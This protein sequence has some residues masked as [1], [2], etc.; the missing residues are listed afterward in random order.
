MRYGRCSVVKENTLK[1]I[2]QYLGNFRD[3]TR[4]KQQLAAELTN[5]SL[6]NSSSRISEK[7]FEEVKELLEQF[8]KVKL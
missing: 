1:N 3:S 7:D 6:A 4:F 2:S 5:L 8:K